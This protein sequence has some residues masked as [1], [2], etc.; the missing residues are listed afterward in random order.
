MSRVLQLERR[1]TQNRSVSIVSTLTCIG[2]GL[3]L[4]AK[5]VWL[6]VDNLKRA[7]SHLIWHG[8]SDLGVNGITGFT[9][10]IHGY[11]G[12]HTPVKGKRHPDLAA[13]VSDVGALS[14]ATFADAFE[15][16][17]DA[18]DFAAVA[19]GDGFR[20][21]AII[22][23]PDLWSRLGK[24]RDTSGSGKTLRAALVEHYPEIKPDQWKVSHN[25]KA[26]GPGG[27][28]GLLAYRSGPMGL[29]YRLSMTPV[30]TSPYRQGLEERIAGA[31]RIGGLMIGRQPGHCMAW[32]DAS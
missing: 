14:A 27:Y 4:S 6:L 15:A 26:T 13:K 30:L 10:T 2:S 18:I 7:A 12:E 31:M 22:M 29:A 19:Y 21:N 5:P 25:L 17:V 20:P 8:S 9:G 1:Y 24:I 28:S 23:G 3:S 16:L 11:A 32:F